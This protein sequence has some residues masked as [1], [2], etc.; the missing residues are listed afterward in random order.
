M[1]NM[2]PSGQMFFVNLY[3][4]CTCKISIKI[5]NRAFIYIR[6]FMDESGFLQDYEPS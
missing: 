1:A 6:K 2:V 4:A 5:E 3:F